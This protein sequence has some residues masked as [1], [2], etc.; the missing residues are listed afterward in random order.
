M[1]AAPHTSWGTLPDHDLK[2]YTD[3]SCVQTGFDFNPR[4]T[5]VEKM[6]HVAG[7]PNHYRGIRQVQIFQMAA[8]MESKLEIIPNAQGKAVGLANVE[9]GTNVTLANFAAVASDAVDPETLHGWTRDPLKLLLAKEVKRGLSP[10]KV[11]EVT[12]PA[13]YY[14]LIALSS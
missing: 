9:A 14:P 1:P 3:T 7:T 5:I 8:D 12:C 11:P 6:G 2:E 4:V 13:S 10:D